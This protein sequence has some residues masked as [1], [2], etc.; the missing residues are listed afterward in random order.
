[1]QC[2]AMQSHSV[3]CSETQLSGDTSAITDHERPSM[4]NTDRN[5]VPTLDYN[6][7]SYSYYFYLERGRIL[8]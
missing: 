5:K 1:M 7:T 3:Q 8:R 6:K 4:L 2:N